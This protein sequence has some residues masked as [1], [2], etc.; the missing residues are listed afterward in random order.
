MNAPRF[1]ARLACGCT[2]T[3][4]AGVEGSPVAVFVDV[5][6]SGCTNPSHVSGLAIYDHREALRPST[7]YAPPVHP[8]YEES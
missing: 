3:F 8:D 1:R 4:R 7:R 6:A 2:L 5:K